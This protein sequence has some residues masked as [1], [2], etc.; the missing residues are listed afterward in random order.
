[1]AKQIIVAMGRGHAPPTSRKAP[2][3]PRNPAG[4][5]LAI[6]EV[7]AAMRA[8][9]HKS[10]PPT[11]IVDA[12]HRG[13]HTTVTA[14]LQAAQP[15][16]R[17]LVRPGLY[18]EALT[19]DKP[20]EI[21]GDGVA[22]EVVIVS[23]IKDKDTITFY[24]NMGRIANLTL[25]QTGGEHGSCLFIG[26]GRLDV[27]DCDIMCSGG[28]GVTVTG[29]ADPRLRRNRIHD[30]GDDGIFVVGKGLGTF[31]DNEIC[32]NTR[33][34]VR[35]LGEAH[36]TLR[37]NRIGENGAVA[38]GIFDGGYG[39]FED[40]DLRGNANGAWAIAPNCLS[41]VVRRNNLK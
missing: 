2:M 20:V 23:E 6:R 26:Q 30:C 11:R 38:I 10:E 21:I 5:N 29:G 39:L 18:C 8:P 16:D 37:R 22:D 13:D 33:Y 27:E 36:P 28:A 35:I 41:K 31:D 34:G 17:I 40:N 14:A 19:I 32:A 9:Q 7:S 3:P 15:G 25:R 24:A 1:M 12:L 4:E